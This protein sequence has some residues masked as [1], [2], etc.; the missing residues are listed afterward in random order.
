MFRR[1]RDRSYEAIA[2]TGNVGDIT[3]SCL[4][5][6]EG[7]AQRRDVNPEISL[8]NKSVRPRAGDQILLAD[9]FVGTLGQSDQ[10]IQRTA[11]ETDRLAILK[12]EL[13][14]WNKPKW[15]ERNRVV[16]EAAVRS[17][18]LNPLVGR[19]EWANLKLTRWYSTFTP[20]ATSR[21]RTGCPA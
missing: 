20:W 12:E 7:P 6:T 14:R 18:T 9:K 11:T 16:A 17:G 13:L 2:P 10:D 19:S 4:S 3:L 1:E 15:P 21:S 8:F 5:V